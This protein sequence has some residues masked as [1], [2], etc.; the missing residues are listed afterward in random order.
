MSIPGQPHSEGRNQRIL[1][2]A[3]P[4]A[5][6]YITEKMTEVFSS[7]KIGYVKWGMN[8]I[9]SDVYSQYLSLQDDGRTDPPVPGHSV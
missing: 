7:A 4:E 5:V 8:R 1:D 3:N 2:L 6:K 9:F